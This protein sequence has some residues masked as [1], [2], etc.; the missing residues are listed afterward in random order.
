MLT[1]IWAFERL[2]SGLL[3]ISPLLPPIKMKAAPGMNSCISP[4]EDTKYDTS[5]IYSSRFWVEI[6]AALLQPLLGRTIV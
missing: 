2:S 3:L 4:A 5:G 6:V 1:D